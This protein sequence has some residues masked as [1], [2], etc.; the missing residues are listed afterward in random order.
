VPQRNVTHEADRGLAKRLL[1][2]DEESFDRFFDENFPRLIR[3]AMSRMRHDASAAEEVVQ[4]TLCAAIAKVGTY[5]GE[6]SLF[7]WLCTFC[8]HEIAAYYRRAGTNP[9]SVSLS[10]DSP[11][12]RGALESLAMSLGDDPERRLAR[13]EVGRL[14]HV[15][16]DSLPEHYASVLE[17]KYMLGM[18]VGDIAARLGMSYK[19]TESLL[20]RARE[21]FREGFMVLTDTPEPA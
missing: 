1:A 5:R 16:L 3:F 7:T 9:P 10:E 19:A 15:A 21:A 8:R 13:R 11:E 20:T 17:W 14:V 12:A 4:A 18:S 2:G 6:A